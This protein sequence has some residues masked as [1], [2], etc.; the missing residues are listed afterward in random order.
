MPTKT[1][2]AGLTFPWSNASA[3]VKAASSVSLLKPAPL[4][5]HRWLRPTG[6]HNNY[7]GDKLVHCLYSM[8][9]ST[10]ICVFYSTFYLSFQTHFASSRRSQSAVVRRAIVHRSRRLR[11]RR[12][13]PIVQ[14]R[15]RGSRLHR[16]YVVSESQNRRKRCYRHHSAKAGQEA[17]SATSPA[18]NVALGRP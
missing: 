5:G 12:R 10:A 13:R 7:P 14:R 18:S 4:P 17:A 15:A 2:N 16:R 1:R 3:A 6:I 9:K 8:I 11:R